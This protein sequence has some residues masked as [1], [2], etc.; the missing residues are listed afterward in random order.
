M[1]RKLWKVNFE[2]SNMML[3]LFN[4]DKIDCETYDYSNINWFKRED[5]WTEPCCVI[6]SMILTKELYL[7]LR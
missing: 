1:M 3:P 2:S 4:F 5:T 6:D 7:I